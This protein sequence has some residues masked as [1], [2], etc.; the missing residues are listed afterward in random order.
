M[1]TSALSDH[2]RLST[3]G[4]AGPCVTVAP[5]QF[6]AVVEAL[7]SAAIVY[8]ADEDAVRL[9]GAPAL[10]VIELGRGADVARVQG[11]LDHVAAE[12]LTRDRNGRRGATRKEL[13]VRGD[14]KAMR[15]FRRRL[16]G[17]SLGDW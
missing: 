14:A 12:L 10:A 8:R 17:T 11:V 16:D 2:L 1:T 6:T 13:I 9:N 3:D 4:T 5:D 15:E 7:R